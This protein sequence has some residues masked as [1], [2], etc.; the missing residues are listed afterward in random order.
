MMTPNTP[1]KA[2]VTEKAVEVAD[3]HI[4]V[5]VWKIEHPEHGVFY[6]WEQILAVNPTQPV[7]SYSHS[8]YREPT[9]ALFEALLN[10]YRSPEFQATRKPPKN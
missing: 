1:H 2:H 3:E 6:E 7:A 8:R 5:M 4:T 9:R 10:W